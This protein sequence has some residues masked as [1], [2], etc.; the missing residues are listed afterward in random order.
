MYSLS[1][2]NL[3]LAPEAYYASVTARKE[4]KEES[5]PVGDHNGSLRIES[6][7]AR[8]HANC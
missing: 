1:L 7:A 5:A 2:P 4:K 3:A 6:E 8:C